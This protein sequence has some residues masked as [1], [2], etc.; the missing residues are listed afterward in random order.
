MELAF[1]S[2]QLLSVINIEKE[3]EAYQKISFVFCFLSCGYGSYTNIYWEY[4]CVFPKTPF[5]ILLLTFNPVMS[6]SSGTLLPIYSPP[7]RF[8]PPHPRTNLEQNLPGIWNT[9][10]HAHTTFSHSLPWW[11]HCVWEKNCEWKFV[12]VCVWVCA[13][14]HV[15]QGGREGLSRRSSPHITTCLH[16]GDD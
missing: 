14:V 16:G 11:K 15:C 1:T 7:R 13:R 10:K 9:H 2:A 3:K 5:L 4:W 8:P 6:T 12:C